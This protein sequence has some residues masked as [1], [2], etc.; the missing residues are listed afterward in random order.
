[1]GLTCSDWRTATPEQATAL[2]V[3]ETRRWASSLD[4]DTSS[5]WEE[6]E[7]GRQAGLVPGV[8]V[9]DGERVMGWSFYLI[10]QGALQVGGFVSRSESASRLMLDAILKRDIVDSVDTVSF[11]AFTD[12]PD[13]GP[14]LRA[15]G[16]SVDR[17]WYLKRDAD[18]SNHQPVLQNA[19]RWR[20]EDIPATAELLAR[21]YESPAE[22]RPFAPRGTPE[23]WLDYVTQLTTASGCGTLLLDACIAI[24]GGANKL[25]AVTL[26]TSI[27]LTV[28]HIAQVAVDPA[29]QGRGVGTTLVEAACGRAARSGYPRV[30]LLVGGRNR[31]ARSLYQTVRFQSGPTF[32]AGGKLN[33]RKPLN[34]TTSRAALTAR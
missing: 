18:E 31:K 30:T 9:R 13:L 34:A 19:R 28:A 25:S 27:S 17:Y 26:V 23:E 15:R 22:A 6:V 3:S 2:Y 1:M 24:P 14:A 33:S 8:I 11:F 32:L 5:N 21:A 4:W 20:P 16:L 12:A 7:K 10:H 29:Q